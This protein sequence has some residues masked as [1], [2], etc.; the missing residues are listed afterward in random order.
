MT[1][2][3][4]HNTHVVNNSQSG[5]CYGKE[6]T[7]FH[8]LESRSTFSAILADNT[9]YETFYAGKYLNTYHGK[10]VPKGWN[11]WAGLIGNSKYYN[12]KLNVNGKL[13]WHGN[14]YTEDY[15]TDVI[16]RLAMDFLRSE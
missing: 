11:Y 15:L 14:N 3:Y 12:Y 10:S 13:E 7:S 5:N 6:W 2:R 16:E 1:G 4:Q 9:N 8:G